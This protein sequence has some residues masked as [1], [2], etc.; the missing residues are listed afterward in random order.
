[1]LVVFIVVM[2]V[3]FNVYLVLLNVYLLV[4]VLSILITYK[5]LVG[6]SHVIVEGLLMA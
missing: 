3:L 6:V 1:M 2:M 4:S 5:F